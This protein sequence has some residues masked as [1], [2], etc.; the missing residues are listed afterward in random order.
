MKASSDVHFPT[1]V[2]GLKLGTKNFP[3]GSAHC[4]IVRS[5][6]W[7]KLQVAIAAKNHVFN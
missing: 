6:W 4:R 3:V 5:F 1:G 2:R 7:E